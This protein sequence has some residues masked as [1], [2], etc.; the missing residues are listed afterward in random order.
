MLKLICADN[1]E[2]KIKN[3][4]KI[5]Q[6]IGEHPFI[7][8]FRGSF[9]NKS[10]KY[11][12]LEYAENGDL[13]EYFYNAEGGVNLTKKQICKIFRETCLAVSHM[14]SRGIFHGDLKLLNL[15][16]DADLTVKLADF[17]S[18]TADEITRNK[19][20]FHSLKKKF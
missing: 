17:G 7:I 14:H 6:K 19:Y 20:I 2:K 18:S 11:I 5:H 10:H 9:E 13:H 16:L 12:V 1:E 4:I 3:E 15:L 8:G